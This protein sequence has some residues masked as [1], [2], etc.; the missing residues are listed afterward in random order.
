MPKKQSAR[1]KRILLVEDEKPIAQTLELKLA[2]SGFEVT[3]AYD[4]ME[5]MA[6]IEQEPF[7]LVLLD[8]VMPE[9]DGFTVLE[10]LKNKKMRPPVIVLTNLGQEE[11]ELRCKALGADDY[12]VKADTPLI[13]IV[14][15]VSR[16]LEIPL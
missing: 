15:R 16:L 8:L 11:D 3:C 6:Y 2:K 1:K 13:T 5:C 14:E 7:D 10:E 4:G 12:F 9:K